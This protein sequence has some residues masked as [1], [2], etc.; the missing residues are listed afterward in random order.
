MD[1]GESI[2]WRLDLHSYA[3]VANLVVCFRH[4]SLVFGIFSYRV[5]RMF[6]YKVIETL[7]ALLA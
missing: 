6:V 1:L 4:G 5:M 7:R 2:R 3:V